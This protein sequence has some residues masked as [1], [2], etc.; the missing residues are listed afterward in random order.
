MQSKLP[1]APIGLSQLQLFTY[2]IACTIWTTCNSSYWKYSLLGVVVARQNVSSLS[3][4]CIT[5]LLLQSKLPH[6][7]IGLFQFQLFTYL[8]GYTIWTTCNSSYWKNS[9]LGV[10]VA[11]QNVPSLSIASHFSCCNLNFHMHPL[12]YLS[13]NCLPT[14]LFVC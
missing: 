5:F 14:W 9:L 13:L 3:I 12:A 6:A 4:A 2:L 11:R 10:V 7:P 8:I 1:H